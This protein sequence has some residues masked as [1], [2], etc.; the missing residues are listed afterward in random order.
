MIVNAARFYLLH[1]FRFVLHKDWTRKQLVKWRLHIMI[2]LQE[3][4]AHRYLSDYNIF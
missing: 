4:M 3:T 1:S 2:N